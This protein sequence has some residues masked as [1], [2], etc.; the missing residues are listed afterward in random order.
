MTGASPT[1]REESYGWFTTPDL[2]TLFNAL[3]R[4]PNPQNFV[5][6]GGQA[7]SFWVDYFEIPIPKL[8]SVYLTQDADFLGSKKDAE[9]LADILGAKIKMA[10]LDDL[11]PNLAVLTYPGVNGEKLYIDVLSVIVGINDNDEI[12]RRAVPVGRDGAILYILHPLLCLKSRIENLRLLPG[13]RNGNGISQ[14]RVAVQVVRSYIDGLLLQAA[15][16]AA[17]GEQPNEREALYAANQIR[18]MA[19]GRASRFVYKEYKIDILDAVDQNAFKTNAFREKNW[20][21]VCKWVN[22]RRSK[23]E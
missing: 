15:M 22:K 5:L 19:L 8:E 10:T 9:I 23:K 12:R 13:K 1:E 2:D 18:D 20:P 4:L 6:V 21:N 14:A 3:K 17:K 16:N 7:L 11:A